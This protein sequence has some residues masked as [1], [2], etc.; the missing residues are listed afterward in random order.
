MSVWMGW[1][2]RIVNVPVSEAREDGGVNK[3]G[4]RFIAIIFFH[5]IWPIKRDKGPA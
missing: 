4:V 5:K 3:S 2:E 1:K